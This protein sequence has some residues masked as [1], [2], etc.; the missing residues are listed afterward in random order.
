MCGCQHKKYNLTLANKF[1]LGG[2]VSDSHIEGDDCVDCALNHFDLDE[3]D[4]FETRMYNDYIKHSTKQEALQL[5]INNVEGDYSQ[6]SP[7]LAELAEKYYPEE[8]RDGGFIDSKRRFTDIDFD[9][10]NNS[11]EFTSS[12]DGDGMWVITKLGGGFHLGKFNRD[13]EYLFILGKKDLS[14]PLVKWLSENSYTTNDEFY[15]LEDGGQADEEEYNSDNDLFAQYD[16]LPDDVRA[17]LDKYSVIEAEEGFDYEILKKFI[18]ELEPLGY[19]FD[20]YLDAEPYNLRELKM[21]D[22][23]GVEKEA[24]LSQDEFISEIHNRTVEVDNNGKKRTPQ[25]KEYWQKSLNR[26]LEGHRSYIVEPISVMYRAYLSGLYKLDDINDQSTGRANEVVGHISDSYRGSGEGFGSSDMTYLISNFLSADGIDAEFVNGRLTRLSPEQIKAKETEG[27]IYNFLH[28]GFGSYNAEYKKLARKIMNKLVEKGYLKRVNKVVGD[29]KS[30]VEYALAKKGYTVKQ[31]AEVV[32][33]GKIISPKGEEGF[34]SFKGAMYADGGG[35][36]GIFGS[37]VDYKGKKIYHFT[38]AFGTPV[39]NAIRDL[40]LKHEGKLDKNIWDNTLSVQKTL[41]PKFYNILNKEW[42]SFKKTMEVEV[43]DGKY[44]NPFYYADGGQVVYIEFLNKDK[45]HQLDKK[46]FKGKDAYEK[47]VKWAKA[48]FE[49]FDPDM[50]KYSFDNG[51]QLKANDLTL[52]TWLKN[53][54]TG[55]KA[56]VW[57]IE[58]TTGRMKLE[59]EYGNKDNMWRYAKDWKVIPIPVRRLKEV[60]LAKME[61]GGVTSSELAFEINDLVREREVARNMGDRFLERKI[62][63]DLDANIQKMDSL[64]K[65]DVSD[66]QYTSKTL[67]KSKESKVREGLRN[68]EISME[69]LKRIIGFEPEYPTQFVGSIKLTKCFLR[70]FYKI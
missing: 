58:P 32:N 26:F 9:R 6:L 31:L 47:A 27:I 1:E 29:G 66:L 53:R 45:N 30:N 60:A 19:T 10:L 43:E 52:G 62:Q 22:G 56:K 11:G 3:L 35:V 46:V 17:V 44:V 24:I 68:G 37:V 51:G 16:T 59:D 70:P 5:L 2:G 42:L 33:Y 54:K 25:A 40:F 15:K 38:V 36:E 69:L 64:R 39:I 34:Y 49:R 67:V 23:G 4:T 20:Y 41:N 13:K 14:N 61:D 18:A 63:S 55:T 12:F 8:Y 50:I 65:S 48:N 7:K 28:W 57:D 21:K